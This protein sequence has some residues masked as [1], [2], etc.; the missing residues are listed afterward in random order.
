MLYKEK[1]TLIKRV[2]FQLSK[3][4]RYKLFF[5]LLLI[6]FSSFAEILSIGAV[7]PFLSILTTPELVTN[8]KYLNFININKA[9]IP[10]YLTLIFVTLIILSGFIKILTLQIQTKISFEI[11]KEF[12]SEIYRKTLYQQYAVH[13]S[14]NTSEII[15]GITI[16]SS[17]VIYSYIMPILT[18]VSSSVLFLFFIFAFLFLNPS[19]LI[20]SISGFGLIYYTI[21][22]TSKKRLKKDSQI[23]SEESNNVFKIL[24]EGLGGIRDVLLDGTQ[25]SFVEIYKNADKKYRKSQSNVIIL[26]QTPRY[27][28]ESLAIAFISILAFKLNTTSNVISSVPLLGALAL[29]AQ[30]IL[31]IVQQS[32]QSWTMIKSNIVTLKD[33]LSLIEQPLPSYLTE[34]LKEKLVFENKIVFDNLSFR[35]NQNNSH[36]VLKDFYLEINKGE[37]IGITGITGSGKSTFLD[38]FM[39]L[40]IPNKGKIIVDDSEITKSNYRAWQSNIAHVPQ[41]IF[42]SDST[43]LENIAFGI[44]KN[45]I[46]LGRVKDAAIKAQIHDTIENLPDKYDTVVGERGVRLSGGQRQ[47]IGI[48]RALYK[49]AKIIIF[50]EATS[51]LDNNTEY[52]VMKSINQLDKELT[53]IIVA[54]RISTLKNCDRI[55]E[56]SNGN[57]SKIGKYDELYKNKN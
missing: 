37:T 3:K 50:D 21:M 4:N 49:N 19:I 31:P 28:V 45:Q 17:N 6:I 22:Q 15:S 52:E 56:F 36:H 27:A 29:G 57:I 13:T 2:W 46:D 39:Y 11:G 7:I 44:N 35:Y 9:N 33:T 20:Y 12:S 40:L 53:I 23:I 51:S 8:S 10:F 38:I 48:A 14:R 34:V 43:I 54:H 24:Q 16:K 55:L 1:N 18:I 26:S 41:A 47:R 32:F 42:L 25:E 30:R 5:L